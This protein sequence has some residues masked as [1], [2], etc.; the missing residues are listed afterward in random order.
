MRLNDTA[1]I[2]R[3]LDL[4]GFGALEVTRVDPDLESELD[5]FLSLRHSC[6]LGCPWPFQTGLGIS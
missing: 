3:R 2:W 5:D 1:L 6:F 4:L